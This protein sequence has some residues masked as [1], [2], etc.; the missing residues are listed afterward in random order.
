M[1]SRLSAVS[2][3]SISLCVAADDSGDV[4]A[5]TD[6]TGGA[7]AWPPTHLLSGTGAFFTGVSC[8]STA[9]CVATASNG[10]VATTTDPADGAGAW[11]VIP[12]SPWT[13]T[14]VSCA[15]ASYCVAFDSLG[16]VW[17]S[18]DPTG[19]S[20]AWS[21][22]FVDD[23]TSLFATVP[24]GRGSSLCCSR[25]RAPHPDGR[26]D[27]P[28]SAGTEDS[29]RSSKRS[30]P[31]RPESPGTPGSARTGITRVPSA[32]SHSSP[33]VSCSSPGPPSRRFGSG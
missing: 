30:S 9:L 21:T 29:R 18:T 24:D 2:C 13:L 31:G 22:T 10:S 15:T 6:P 20:A 23:Q 33:S 4:L 7:S 1:N 3:A 17:T 28:R 26:R 8:P 32:I 14:N 16:N 27:R 11:Q 5:S 25:E 12:I 19:G